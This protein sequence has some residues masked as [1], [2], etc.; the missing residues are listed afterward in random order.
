VIQKNL[1]TN[2]PPIMYKAYLLFFFGLFTQHLFAQQLFQSSKYGYSFIIPDGWRIKNQIVLPDTDAKIVDDKGNS[3]IVSVKPLPAEFKGTTSVSL[4]SKASDQ[5]LIDLWAP[6][7]DNSYVLRRG[8]TV[9]GG[10]EFYFVHMS[11]PFEGNL[12]L[13][14]K[15]FM[16]NWKGNSISIDCASISS[17]TAET[18]VYFDVMIR[19][20]KF[21]LH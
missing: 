17:M 18:S 12:R 5:D 8:T 6:S 1:T 15:M 3:F 10:K 2:K 13:I 21:Q 9:I 19:S 4:L 14:H 20:F 11:C 16:Y 7:Y